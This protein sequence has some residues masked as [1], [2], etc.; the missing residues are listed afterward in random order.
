[1]QFSYERGGK[2]FGYKVGLHSNAVPVPGTWLIWMKA[3]P[4][5]RR[6]PGPWSKEELRKGMLAIG[7]E[8]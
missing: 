1:L 7:V 8:R 6:P 4:E 3:E 5:Y 2:M